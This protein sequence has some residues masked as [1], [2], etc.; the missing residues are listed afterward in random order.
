MPEYDLSQF[1]SNVT[2]PAQSAPE[3]DLSQFENA[4]APT[5]QAPVPSFSNKFDPKPIIEGMPKPLAD[6]AN[7]RLDR[8]AQEQAPLQKELSDLNNA[9]DIPFRIAAAPSVQFGAMP[10]FDQIRESFDA[11]QNLIVKLQ[12][13]IK[14]K[15]TEFLRDLSDIEAE[16]AIL[17][18]KGKD[19]TT[20]RRIIPMPPGATDSQAMETSRSTLRFVVSPSGAVFLGGSKVDLNDLAKKDP[21]LARALSGGSEVREL[22]RSEGA[23][24]ALEDLSGSTDRLN[25]LKELKPLLERSA[26]FQGDLAQST[27]RKRKAVRWEN[28]KNESGTVNPLARQREEF[29]AGFTGSLISPASFLARALGN[30]EIADELDRKKGSLEAPT[31]EAERGLVDNL[32]SGAGSML[33]FMAPGMG[34][35]GMLAKMGT[36]GRWAASLVAGSMEAAAE[37][38]DTYTSARQQG[39][40]DEAAKKA[41]WGTFVANVPLNILL[42]KIGVMNSSAGSSLK[43][44]AKAHGAEAAQE[45]AQQ[46]IQNVALGRPWDEGVVDSALVG[47]ILGG[48]TKAIE[49]ISRNS[50]ASSINEE[51][52]RRNEFGPQGPSPVVVDAQMQGLTPGVQSST[53]K[54]EA[55]NENQ[56]PKEVMSS[57]QEKGQEGLQVGISPTAVLGQKSLLERLPQEST[58]QWIRREAEHVSKNPESAIEQ[59]SQTPGTN[60]GSVI[61]ADHVGNMFGGIQNDPVIGWLVA[62]NE[63]ASSIATELENRAISQPVPEGKPNSIAIVAGPQGSGK[64][65]VANSITKNNKAAYVFDGIN[66]DP[67]SVFETARKIN[68]SGKKAT[69]VMVLAPLIT[70]VERNANRFKKE[71]RAVGPIDQAQ[72]MFKARDMLQTLS[73]DSS[74]PLESHVVVIDDG[75]APKR[76][77]IEQGIEWLNKE[78]AGRSER[79][80]AKAAL[81]KHIETIERLDNAQQFSEDQ[82]DALRSAA[83]N[84]AEYGPELYAEYEQ[85]LGGIPGKR[86]LRQ[87]VESN[88]GREQQQALP[89][90]LKRPDITPEGGRQFSVGKVE[91]Q[92]PADRPDLIQRY[93]AAVERLEQT[94][95]DIRDRIPNKEIRAKLHQKA[96]A[97]FA[98]EKLSI[99][100]A[101]I[102][103]ESRNTTPQT[104]ITPAPKQEEP[105]TNRPSSPEASTIASDIISLQRWITELKPGSNAYLS[106]MDTLRGAMEDLQAVD[107]GHPV[108]SGPGGLRG[109]MAAD[110]LGGQQIYEMALSKL[111]L[112]PD[113]S[114]GEIKTAVLQKIGQIGSTIQMTTVKILNKMKELGKSFANVMSH[115]LHE[116]S[117]FQ[118]RKGEIGAVG[119]IKWTKN[120]SKEQIESLEHVGAIV[121]KQSLWDRLTDRVKEELSVQKVVDQFRPLLDLDPKAYL[122]ARMS[123]GSDGAVEALVTFGNIFLRDGV[124]DADATGKGFVEVMRQLQGEQDRFMWWVAARRAEN[125]TREGRENLFRDQDIDQLK[126]LNQGVMP[127]GQNRSFLY[128]KT[129][130]E[131][132]AIGR[133]VLDLA[134]QSGTIDPES[135]KIWEKEFYVPFYRAMEDKVSG[136]NIS[137]SG[138][139]VRQYAFKELKGGKGKLNNDL[140]Y[141]T[142]MNWSHLVSSAAKNR[143]ASAA[144]QAAENA[145]IAT[146]VNSSENADVWY[147]DNGNKVYYKVEDPHVMSAIVALESMGMNKF[148]KIG[149][150]FKRALT[151][152][153]TTNPA[154]KIRNLIRDSIATIAISGIS[155]NVLKNI[156]SGSKVM[157]KKKGQEYASILASGAIIRFGTMLEGGTSNHLQ[158]MI[159]AGI[160]E[161]TIVSKWEHVKDIL[162]KGLDVYNEL[163][164]ISE[165]ANRAALYKQLR[166][167][168]KTHAEAAFE[169]RDLLDFTMS[170]TSDVVRF[171][172][173]VVPFMNARIQ[174]INKLQKGARENPIR[175]SATLGAVALASIALMLKY[176]DD[177][178]WKKR[179][180]WDR[181]NYWWFKIGDKAFRIPKPFE[182]GS[183]GTIAERSVESFVT[184]E[185][186]KKRFMDRIKAMLL[187]T[188]AMNPTPQAVK[189]I[190]DLWANKDPFSGRPIE[191]QGQEKLKKSERFSESTSEIS[192]TLGKAGVLSPVQI[193]YLVRSYLGW[194]GTAV[195]TVSSEAIRPMLKEGDRPDRRLSDM[196]LIGNFVE[197]LP[198]NRS[199]YLTSFYEQAKEIEQTFET[200][201][202]MQKRGDKEKAKELKDDNPKF[203]QRHQIASQSKDKISEINARIKKVFSDKSMKGDDKRRI[204]DGLVSQRNEIARKAVLKLQMPLK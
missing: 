105:P 17:S 47:G 24:G 166:E 54:L 32:S 2:T 29:R 60:G 103:E 7:K 106:A 21:G 143:A 58:F 192:K 53:A 39:M 146:R 200:Y 28:L 150:K 66:L 148:V 173:T 202:S 70:I 115:L 48:G 69:Y 111:G 168:G 96:G 91:H 15:E 140:I 43:R 20:S 87:D 204:I 116:A 195:L 171:L 42:D 186:T 84:T 180:D 22:K 144:L 6:F 157:A 74:V 199:R 94:H 174:G 145:G 176:K 142:M 18:G 52:R 86:G 76:V 95:S 110:F 184:D 72:N 197:S 152:G 130:A 102:R 59:Y 109:A 114:I 127:D 64:S 90:K 163:G 73:E 161:N 187:D 123:K 194:L 164:D 51:R 67:Q 4:Q 75:V 201:R 31:P 93:D 23:L 181:D 183:I 193:D 177:D 124:T 167:Q 188:F 132:N 178:E 117:P 153:V 131:F 156:A 77:S 3:Y 138:G 71:G 101:L 198:S 41:M 172:T 55:S 203:G 16:S 149:S 25:R 12:D 139:L 34:T 185:M 170:G 175:F 33:A 158:K 30:N 49:Q 136:P 62:P 134:E 46:V 81:E 162:Q 68:E 190:Y 10:R 119:N 97:T 165:G 121:E 182:V 65:S 122:L 191:S 35:S 98:S 128:Y 80:L 120:L 78:I 100:D 63:E 118:G 137:G 141:N 154:F 88:R 179:E 85:R 1:E 196:F 92:I 79:D 11:K 159:N 38:G 108:L 155:P 9:S 147:L 50:V 82:F 37:A 89:A 83:A 5:P 26:E 125:L 135:R 133:S 8:L 56:Q 189:P 99:A 160:K 126:K 129:L 104:E 44:I 14:K 113:A 40:T 151:I 13:R 45:A 19:L 107:S 112:G 57:G 36:G 169:A 61:G 27:S